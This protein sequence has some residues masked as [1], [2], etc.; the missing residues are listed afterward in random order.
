M[1]LVLMLGAMVFLW[2]LQSKLA[3]YSLSDA[4][5]TTPVAKLIQDKQVNKSRAPQMLERQWPVLAFAELV[6]VPVLLRFTVRRGRQARRFLV[7]STPGFS[8]SLFL[9][10][11]PVLV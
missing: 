10:P 9:R 7:N 6:V 11:P 8:D 5:H 4:S 2:G 3:Q 1:G